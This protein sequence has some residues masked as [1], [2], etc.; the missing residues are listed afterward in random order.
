MGKRPKRKPRQ[1]PEKATPEEP[2]APDE[3]AGKPKKKRA[4]RSRSGVRC[5]VCGRSGERTGTAGRARCGTCGTVFPAERPALGEVAKARDRRFSRA[6]A[7]PNYEE[8]RQARALAGEAMRGFFE[9]RAGK[10]A[11]LNAFGKNVL[12]V[13]CGLG[14]RLRAFQSYG[15]WAAGTETSAT[16]YEYARRQSLDVKHGW[17]DEGSFG[18]TGFDLALF[19]ASFGELPDPRKAVGKLREVLRPDGLVCVL[20]EPLTEKGGELPDGD[21]RLLLYTAD[22]LKR[23]FCRDGFSFVSEKLGEGTGTFWFKVKSRKNK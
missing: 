21:S 18:R 2:K 20:R 7:L 14:F 9:I 23:A 16:A 11:A 22:S 1:S 8:R 6:F 15:W 13:N 10:P 5:P 3:G 17:L 19:C 12:E 4:R